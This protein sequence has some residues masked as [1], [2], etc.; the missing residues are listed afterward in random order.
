[1]RNDHDIWGYLSF[2]IHQYRKVRCIARQKLLYDM[3]QYNII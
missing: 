2:V 3:I 1:M